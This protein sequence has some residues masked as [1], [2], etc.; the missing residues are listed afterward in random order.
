MRR[1]TDGNVEVG[2]GEC[3]EE[4]SCIAV[5]CGTDC[6]TGD[7]YLIGEGLAG[8]GYLIGDGLAGEGC[9]IGEDCLAGEGCLTG[10][11]E[12]R[13]VWL[14]VSVRACFLTGGFPSSVPSGRFLVFPSSLLA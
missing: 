7:G 9:L 13:D 5:L 4:V 8:D 2:R 11:G 6:L 14:E 3:R 1:G 10:V 12:A